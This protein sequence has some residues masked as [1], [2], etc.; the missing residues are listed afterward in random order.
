MEIGLR[1]RAVCHFV[2]DGRT[3]WRD[4]ARSGFEQWAMNWFA[5][6]L[7][8]GGWLWRQISIA[9]LRYRLAEITRRHE[10]SARTFW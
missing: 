3:R 10:P 4:G 2:V 6:E 5:E 1:K 9:W 8:S 7:N